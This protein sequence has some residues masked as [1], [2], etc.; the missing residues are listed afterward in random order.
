ML[1]A[2][3]NREALENLEEL[4]SL[5]NQVKV[6]KLQDKLGKQNFHEDMK[7]VFEP[8]TKSLENTSENLTKAITETSIKNNQAIENINNNL[9][10]IMNDRGILATYLMSPLSRI[11]NPENASQFKLVK[12][13]SSNRVND[14]KINKTIPITLYGNM[15]TFRD[16]SKQFELKG[17]LLEMI[18]NSKFN[19]DLASLS[20]KKL[21]YDFA[22]EMYFDLNAPGN[23]STRDRKLIKLLNTPGLMV[24]ASGVSKTIFLSFDPNEL[25]DKLKLL[26]REEQAGNNSEII[27]HEIIAI[28]D[29]VLEYKCI[30]KKQHKQILIRC[31]LL[32]KFE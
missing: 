17:D 22:K 24:S 9:L 13:P 10:E 30:T 20:D 27:N 14:L 26:L 3:K 32:H 31:N 23:K 1:Y 11:T 21:M 18:T 8:V 15:L 12:D 4:A 19:V 25:C 29:K 7:K 6:V 2:I 28:I 16:T 5:E